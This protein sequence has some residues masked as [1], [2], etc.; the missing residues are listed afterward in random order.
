MKGLYAGHPGRAHGVELSRLLVHL[1]DQT[2]IV[3]LL[4]RTASTS[5]DSFSCSLAIMQIIK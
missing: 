2:Q 3:R 1:A 5:F 4:S